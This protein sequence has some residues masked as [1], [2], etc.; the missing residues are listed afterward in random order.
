MG[1]S[2]TNI[3]DEIR[4]IKDVLPKKQQKLC[5]WLLMNYEQVGIM[6][7]AEVA[8]AADVGTTTVMRLVQLLGRQSFGELKKDFLDSALSR[9]SNSYKELKQSIKDPA[10]KKAG[11]ALEAV[12]GDGI[13]VLENL[14]TPANIRQFDAAVNLLMNAERIFTVG[15]RS[16]KAIALYFEY[17]L[18]A[19]CPKVIQLSHD[20]E[21]LFDRLTLQIS[22]QDV[23]LTF[24]AW[25]CTIRTIE[26]ARYCHEQGTPVVLVTNTSLNPIAKSADAIIDTNAVNHTGGSLALMAVAESLVS[27]MGR[28]TAPESIQNIERIEAVLNERKLV[29]SEY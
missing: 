22:P 28:R 6:T 29:L 27:E 17:A 8:R 19:F 4:Q 14:C 7:V 13:S 5:S 24:S 12:T 1:D 15:L 2:N 10:L 20:P 9:S 16:S 3:L 26:A 21:F 18:S 23:L 11:A 25:P